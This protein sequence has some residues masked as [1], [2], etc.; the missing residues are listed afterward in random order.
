VR[1][2]RLKIL[3]VT[4]AAFLI[5]IFIMIT[6]RAN[7]IPLLRVDPRN[8]EL[9]RSISSLEEEIA[10]LEEE[11][12]LID[13]QI[14]AIHDEQAEGESYLSQLRQIQEELR[15][16]ACQTELAGPGLIITIDDNKE[17]A[18]KAKASS[19]ETFLPEYYI[20]HDKDLLYIV[21]ALAPF[22]EAIAIN[23]VRL[24]DSSH[25]RCAGTVILVNYAILAPPYEIRV[26]GDQQALL[27]SLQ[28]SSRYQSLINKMMPVKTVSAEKL[29]LPGYNGTYAPTYSKLDR[30]ITAVPKLYKGD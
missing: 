9:I 14:A 30:E 21:R 20:V 27:Q 24:N 19:P 6:I 4:F 16:N 22:S 3:F 25:I 29:T 10:N 8:E 13:E 15:Q 18:D 1:A 26:I 5:G 23:N 7:N 17:G 2:K 12:R 28:T 11:R